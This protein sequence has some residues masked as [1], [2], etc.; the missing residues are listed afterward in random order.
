M[1][2]RR[3]TIKPT[4]PKGNTMT[5]TL[6]NIII[7][8]RDGWTGRY[9]IDDQFD[10]AGSRAYERAFNLAAACRFPGKARD[11]ELR[12]QGFSRK[13]EKAYDEAMIEA[14]AEYHAREA[15]GGRTICPECGQR[16]V[17]HHD[18]ITLGYAGHPGAEHSDYAK[19]ERDGCD[20]AAL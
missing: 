20:Y 11:P 15:A 13:T 8:L 17:V 18:T 12:H 1:A 3:L 7:G 2:T 16:S 4:Q 19:C 9:E 6:N 5:M 10:P 14:E